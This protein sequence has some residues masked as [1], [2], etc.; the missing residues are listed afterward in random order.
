MK[1]EKNLT[2]TQ[3]WN[4]VYVKIAITTFVL[5][6][7][8]YGFYWFGHYYLHFDIY[9][10]RSEIVLSLI[11]STISTITIVAAIFAISGWREQQQSL[12]HS[13]YAKML[14]NSYLNLNK[15]FLQLYGEFQIHLRESSNGGEPM[16][17]YLSRNENKLHAL[18]KSEI[19]ELYFLN[20][21]FYNMVKEEEIY[22]KIKD[23]IAYYEIGIDEVSN[24]S[25]QNW[26]QKSAYFYSKN[27]DSFHIP[28]PIIL[29]TLIKYLTFK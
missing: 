22:F 16:I 5:F 19:G 27:D 11:A 7:C 28:D 21:V 17:E 25:K 9:K 18:K 23:M 12:S 2:V 14:L 24:H 15:K 10:N 20:E 4:N 1:S 13:E 6:V 26:F 29:D 8:A 3:V